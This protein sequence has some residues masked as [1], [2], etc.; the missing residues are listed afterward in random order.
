MKDAEAAA[1]LRP[2]DLCIVA[3]EPTPDRVRLTWH[4]FVRLRSA[5][6]EQ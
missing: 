1:K 6:D 4:K 5:K 2:G 3:H